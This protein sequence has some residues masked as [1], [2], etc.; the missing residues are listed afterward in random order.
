MQKKYLLDE[1]RI[2]RRW[3]NIAPDF[4]EPPAPPLHPG[5]GQPAGPD[6]LAALL[7]H[8]PDRPGSL[9]GALHRHPRGD[10]R[11][12]PDLE[13]D[14]ADPR[15]RP[16]EGARPARRP[17]IFFKYEGVSPSGS[18]KSNTAVAQAYYNSRRASSASPPRRAPASGAARCRW[19][20]RSS[21]STSGL[22]GQGELPPEAV[23]AHADAALRRHGLPQP[24]RPHRDRP[25]GPG[26]RP[27]QS[28]AA[29]ASPSPRRS[30][31]SWPTPARSTALGSV[32]NHVLLHQT[33][34]G[35]EAHRAGR[36]RRRLPRRRG[37]LR[38]RRL[39]LRRHRL[40]LHARDDRRQGQ[41]ALR[42]RRTHGL[43]VADQG[44]LRLRLRR[45]RP[46]H[47][48]AQDVHAGAR[49]HAGRHPRRRPAL[50]RHGAAHQ[51][52]LSPR[53][54]WRR[55]RCRRPRSSRRPGSSPRPRASCRRPSRPTPSARPST[56]PWRP[57]DE[58]KPK[59]IL[60]NLTGHG[61]LDLGAY[62]QFLAGK[63]QDYDHPEEAIKAAMTH[64]PSA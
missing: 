3:Y 7:P 36:R 40:P 21:T 33:V 42:R 16:R 5:T 64:V 22:H 55:W 46:D 20:A 12:L 44:R 49:L 24:H 38:R 25:Q 17:A 2:P 59:T 56:R 13:A 32:L 23:P 58:G 18:H 54:S 14:A 28:A 43:P 34:I 57:K 19:P 51:P 39:E 6:D 41:D 11:H 45:R 60:F 47:A 4:P 52:R 50:P 8:G 48:A 61:L 27:R 1:E 63:L 26:G 31:T 62:E 37:R 10:P 9:D 15:H 29:W 30:R 53:A 35:E